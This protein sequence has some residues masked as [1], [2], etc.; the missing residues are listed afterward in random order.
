[1]STDSENVIAQ[2]QLRG[3]HGDVIVR[4]YLPVEEAGSWFC[5]WR[6]DGIS[7]PADLRTGG[8]DSIH[9]LQLALRMVN[10][11][12]SAETGLTWMGEPVTGLE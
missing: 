1:V 11:R 10:S 5:R 7:E 9:A 12:L 3:E 2:R 6:I 4:I 8:V